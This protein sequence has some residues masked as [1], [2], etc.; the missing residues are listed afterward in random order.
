MISAVVFVIFPLCLAIAAF[1]DLFTM[2]IPNRASVILAVTF[3]GVAT[4]TGMPFIVLGTHLVAAFA[5]L[6]VCFVLFALNIMGGGDAKLLA[7][8]ALWFGF[9]PALIEFLVY[10]GV[11][12]GIITLLILLIRTQ[13]HV[14]LAVGLPVPSSILLAKKIPYGIAIAAGGFIAFPSSPIFVAAL[15]GLK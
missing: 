6:A 14:I 4:A 8:A 1:S 13:A 5:V 9:G 2:T 15:E 3:L 11:F 12:G 10:V 7:A